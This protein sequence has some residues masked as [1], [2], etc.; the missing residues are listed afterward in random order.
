MNIAGG[1]ASI[2]RGAKMEDE[3]ISRK[4]VVAKGI[5]ERVIT[6]LK[7]SYLV[8]GLKSLERMTK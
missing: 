5:C 6:K 2:K 3:I 7:E 4:R 1:L 8:V